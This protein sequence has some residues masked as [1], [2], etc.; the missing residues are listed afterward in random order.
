M[1]PAFLLN[2]YYFVFDLLPVSRP[3]VCQKS[4]FMFK[5]MS[6]IFVKSFFTCVN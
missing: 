3:R 2:Y 1:V 5:N 4:F 6:F